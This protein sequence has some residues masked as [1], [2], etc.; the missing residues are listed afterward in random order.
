[1]TGSQLH[2]LAATAASRHTHQTCSLQPRLLKL[3]LTR[4]KRMTRHSSPL[5]G[6]RRKEDLTGRLNALSFSCLLKLLCSYNNVLTVHLC[7]QLIIHSLCQEDSC[8][9]LVMIKF[10]VIEVTG[11][12]FSLPRL[13]SSCIFYFTFYSFL[14]FQ[15]DML[16]LCL[17]QSSFAH[18]VMS[19]LTH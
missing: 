18:C 9:L 12:S 4:E 2:H 7:L 14:T 10:C 15:S 11:S 3:T 1:M 5:G 16:V 19:G 6:R 17:C 8:C 13:L